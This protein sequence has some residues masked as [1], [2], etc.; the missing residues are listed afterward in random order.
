MHKFVGRVILL[1]YR[2]NEN[3]H[4]WM[5]AFSILDKNPW[6]MKQMR[7]LDRHRQQ[8][9][10]RARRTL[11]EVSCTKRK[12]EMNVRENQRELFSYTGCPF[13][14]YG[15]CFD[16]KKSKRCDIVGLL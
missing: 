7:E 2:E 1:N 3:L 16:Y 10:A 8:V 14:Y 6:S 4:S 15:Q 9:L 13:S 11:S 12:K 5:S